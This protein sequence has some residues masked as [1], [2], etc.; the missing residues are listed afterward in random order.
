M[1]SR[2][3]TT[4]PAYTVVKRSMNDLNQAGIGQR[5]A[6][7]MRVG[8]QVSARDLTKPLVPTAWGKEEK[9]VRVVL[10]LGLVLLA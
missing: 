8:I 1:T 3:S 9:A 5:A 6:T 10:G 2:G 4:G 7:S